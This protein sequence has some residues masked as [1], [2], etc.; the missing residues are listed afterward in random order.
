MRGG[1][2]KL[3][4]FTIAALGGLVAFAQWGC[5]QN[6]EVVQEFVCPPGSTLTTVIDLN[7]PERGCEQ[8]AVMAENALQSFHLRT[9]CQQID[10]AA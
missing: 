6:S 1:S 5:R 7:Y 3:C 2:V 8:A 9:Q 4:P 10:G